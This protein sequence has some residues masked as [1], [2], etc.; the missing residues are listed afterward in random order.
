MTK[1]LK[2]TLNANT[3]E[4][5]LYTGYNNIESAN[6]TATGSRCL[7]NAMETD[8]DCCNSEIELGQILN[9]NGNIQSGAGTLNTN[10]T[11]CNNDPEKNKLIAIRGDFLGNINIC[12]Q[13]ENEANSNRK[14]VEL[15]TACR[16]IRM[17]N[18]N[19]MLTNFCCGGHQNQVSPRHNGKI[20]DAEKT[21]YSPSPVCE[22]VRSVDTHK[23]SSNNNSS[24]SSKR[25]C[26]SSLCPSNATTR[27]LLP[28]EC[29]D[30][31]SHLTRLREPKNN[32]SKK[33][34]VILTPER[35][36]SFILKQNANN[37]VS[38]SP[39]KNDFLNSQL[40]HQL[41]HQNCMNQLEFR[42]ASL[43]SGNETSKLNLHVQKLI[44]IEE[45]FVREKIQRDE[46]KRKA[47]L[48]DGICC[49]FVFFL[50]IVCSAFIFIIL[51]NFKTNS[52]MD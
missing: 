46:W 21:V 3:N 52:L 28:P 42:N 14:N 12:K 32:N 48:C 1:N 9:C 7:C 27:Q 6:G 16:N 33:N 11:M 19:W 38:C 4:E 5:N 10:G 39:A 41:Q 23:R 17:A 18:G 51:P 37:K 43:A 36:L 31:S 44:K 15:K 20:S 22:H 29:F 35:N 50:L 8:A 13:N 26:S 30:Y 24:G 49:L 25:K 2:A 47:R 34:D 40:Y 45:L